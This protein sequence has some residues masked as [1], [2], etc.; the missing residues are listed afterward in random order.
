MEF[1]G[2]GRERWRCVSEGGSPT[3]FDIVGGLLVFNLKIVVQY[4]THIKVSF[5]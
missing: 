4:L 3:T 5:L 1:V 2:G